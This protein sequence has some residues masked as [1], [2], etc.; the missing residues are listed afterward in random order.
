VRVKDFRFCPREEVRSGE[1]RDVADWWE[2]ARL[3][4]AIFSAFR[5]GGKQ[6]LGDHEVVGQ[7][8]P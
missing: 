1:G 6:S 4:A 7:G 5:S 2:G 3:L 8:V